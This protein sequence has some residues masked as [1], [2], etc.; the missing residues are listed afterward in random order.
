MIERVADGDERDDIETKRPK[1]RS[2]KPSRF[3][4]HF[5]GTLAAAH[6]DYVP[7]RRSASI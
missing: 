6:T 7:C 1:R 2:A 3:V 5:D 4:T